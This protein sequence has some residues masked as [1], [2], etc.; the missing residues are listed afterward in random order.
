MLATR[1]DGTSARRLT[2]PRP[3]FPLP[4]YYVDDPSKGAAPGVVKDTSDKEIAGKLELL[5]AR[6]HRHAGAG[7]HG[8]IRPAVQLPATWPPATARWLLA[9]RSPDPGE[10]PVLTHAALPILAPPPLQ[11]IDFYAE[12]GSLTALMGGSGA[13]K[14]SP[15]RHQRWST[16]KGRHGCSHAHMRR[17]PELCC[18]TLNATA[19][20]CLRCRPPL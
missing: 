20:R 8:R 7:R 16:V 15:G 10:M 3:S 13:G 1:L 18:P 14:V 2:A 5:K 17:L 6:G 19:I 4:R 9:T 11:G 12:P